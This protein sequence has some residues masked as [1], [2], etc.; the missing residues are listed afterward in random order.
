[1]TVTVLGFSALTWVAHARLGI[2]M[3][4]MKLLLTGVSHKTAP[5]EVRECLAFREDTLPAALAD[6]KSREGVMEAVI[7]STCN[8]VEITVTTDDAVDPQ[9]DRGSLPGRAQSR[10][11]PPPLRRTSTG[12]KAGTPSITCSAW[13]PAWI[14]W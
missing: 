7:L 14:P 9:R 3:P 11:T 10:S 1:M 12:T 5:V 4:T 13:P 2:M 8:R 6:L